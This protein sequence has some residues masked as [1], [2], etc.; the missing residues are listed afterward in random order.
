M[1]ILLIERQLQNVGND[2]QT[3]R[4]DLSNRSIQLQDHLS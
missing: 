4:K 2:L 3:P 1:I